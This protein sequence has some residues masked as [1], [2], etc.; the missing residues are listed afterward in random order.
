[1]TSGFS[2]TTS[3]NRR[4]TIR[5]IKV[6]SIIWLSMK[7]LRDFHLA[8]TWTSFTMK[9]DH[10]LRPQFRIGISSTTSSSARYRMHLSRSSIQLS[11]RKTLFLNNRWMSTDSAWNATRVCL[12]PQISDQGKVW[13]GLSDAL[14]YIWAL[15]I[16]QQPS[17]SITN[18]KC[19]TWCC[20]AHQLILPSLAREDTLYWFLFFVSWFLLFFFRIDLF[21][22]IQ[23]ING[24]QNVYFF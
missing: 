7:P 17:S 23:A 2:D 12:M 6:S 21:T 15:H 16:A 18:D 10:I 22:H 20:R 8:I 11:R 5:G 1:M 24:M 9:Q 13:H 4:L 19:S 14:L 3:N